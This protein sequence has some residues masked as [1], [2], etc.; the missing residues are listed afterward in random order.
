M[1]NKKKKC[2]TDVGT[3]S[4]TREQQRA[5]PMYRKN[6]RIHEHLT[7]HMRMCESQSNTLALLLSKDFNRQWQKASSANGYEDY[8]GFW[9]FTTSEK[10]RDFIMHVIEHVYINP[11]PKHRSLQSLSPKHDSLSHVAL[12]HMCLISFSLPIPPLPP[13]LPLCAPQKAATLSRK[14]VPEA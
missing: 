9:G 11:S 12:S 3:D 14:S 5:N 13:P 10:N 4:E 7:K 2:C 6:A 8:F 1:K